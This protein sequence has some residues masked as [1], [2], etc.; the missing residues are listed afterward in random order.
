MFYYNM[1]QYYRKYE[2]FPDKI[3]ELYESLEIH[4]DRAGV[5]RDLLANCF[6]WFKSSDDIQF[7]KTAI[8]RSAARYPNSRT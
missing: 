3:Y 4:L 2:S 6:L 7:L 8:A 1:D 5:D